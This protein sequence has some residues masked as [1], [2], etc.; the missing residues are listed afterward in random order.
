MPFPVED[1][2]MAA[3]PIPA[4]G[5]QYGPCPERCEHKSCEALRGSAA[6]PCRICGK[7]IGYDTN[8]F[9]E[10]YDATEAQRKDR[11]RYGFFVHAVCLMEEVAAKRERLGGQP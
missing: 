9:D 11:G 6:C 2:Q 1:S 5:T 7:P 4:P 3:L 10:W 8:C